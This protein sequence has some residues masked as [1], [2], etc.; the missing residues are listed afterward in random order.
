MAKENEQ[1]SIEE[2]KGMIE[3][4]NET[5]SKLQA[6]H[7]ALER[8]VAEL[9]A[10]LGEKN[11]ELERSKRLAALGELAAGVAHEI[12]NPLGGIELSASLLEG[13]AETDSQ[14]KLVSKVLKGVAM[15]NAI[16]TDMLAFTNYH[17][18]D[19]KPVGI[20]SI[21]GEALEYA[22]KEISKRSHTVE[23]RLSQDAPEVR[24]DST[25]LVR[26]FLNLFLNAAQAMGEPG[27]ITVET[28]S[29][30]G[31]AALRITDTG[32]GL[33]EEAREKLF[34]PFFTTKHDG[35]GLGLSIVHKIVK[36]HDGEITA[37]N[38]PDGGA[39]FTVYLPSAGGEA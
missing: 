22:E 26:A 18:P 12:R 39:V 29:K 31:R 3:L 13:E 17:S 8:R 16:V 11:R 30:K 6:S 19:F 35:T 5:T 9:Q 7:S 28:F 34:N 36:S 21:V 2:L 37:H 1:L 4:F 23:R 32:P 25:H 33:E 14:K 10:E 38:A 24:A 27:R 15:L 20:N